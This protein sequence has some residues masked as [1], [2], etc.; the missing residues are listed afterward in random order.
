MMR[1]IIGASLQFRLLVLATA[2]AIV[3]F[4]FRQMSDVQ[5]DLL[6]EFTR[7]TVVIQTE[8][9]GLSAAEVESLITT[10]LEAD[11]LSGM[12]WTDEIRSES[13]A[14]LSSIHIIFKTGTNIL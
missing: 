12:P 5:V 13:I 4:G 2:A 14:G 11:M 3:F 8:A 10:P 9:L 6:P 1:W 7:P